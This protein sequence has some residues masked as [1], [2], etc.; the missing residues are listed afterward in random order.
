MKG[1]TK[2]NRGREV[3]GGGLMRTSAVRNP[4]FLGVRYA[5]RIATKDPKTF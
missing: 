5:F 2:Y 4:R 3:G 1:N